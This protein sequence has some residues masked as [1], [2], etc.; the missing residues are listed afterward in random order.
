MDSPLTT[1]TCESFK[2]HSNIEL[3]VRLFPKSTVCS[4][5]INSYKVN[6]LIA[7]YKCIHSHDTIIEV[8]RTNN[9]VVQSIISNIDPRIDDI[10]IFNIPVLP[11]ESNYTNDEIFTGTFSN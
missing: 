6:T 4:F 9:I 2:N 5:E 10:L 11:G 3:L 7:L 1:S 8:P